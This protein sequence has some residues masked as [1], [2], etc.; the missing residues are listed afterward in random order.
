MFTLKK[1]E[2]ARMKRQ[3]QSDIP[4]LKP[5]RKKSKSK[6]RKKRR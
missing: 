2:V 5:K 6:R 1:S 4:G 3:V